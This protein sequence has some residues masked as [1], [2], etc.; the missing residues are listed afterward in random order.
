[1]QYPK[2]QSALKA[3]WNEIYDVQI[4]ALVDDIYPASDRI[5]KSR[6]DNFFLWDVIGKNNEWYTSTEVL[7]AKTYEEQMEILYNYLMI[8]KDWMNTEINNFN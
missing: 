7:A 4:Q 5:A 2:F 8:R 3:R 1:M 6:Y